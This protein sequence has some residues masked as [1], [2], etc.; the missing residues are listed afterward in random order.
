MPGADLPMNYAATRSRPGGPVVAF[1]RDLRA[2]ASLQQRVAES[3]QEMEREYARIRSAEKRY[4]LL[5]Q[6]AAEPV[7]ILDAATERI[8]EA[9]PAAQNLFGDALRKSNWTLADGLAIGTL[10]HDFRG[11]GGGDSDAGGIAAH[12]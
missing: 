6:Q 10:H 7:L 12:H 11:G 3:Q 4:R 1:G 9:N 2:F 5:F 8:D